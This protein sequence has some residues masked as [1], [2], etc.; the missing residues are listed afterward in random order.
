MPDRVE[1]LVLGRGKLFQAGTRPEFQFQGF[2]GFDVAMSHDVVIHLG[3]PAVALGV[4]G[5]SVRA[6]FVA[7]R[8]GFEILEFVCRGIE[9]KRAFVC[10]SAY[11]ALRINMERTA[12]AR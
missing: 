4:D 3:P 10:G 6:A 8:D 7:G 11:V 2:S 1:L 9:T 12:D 5:D